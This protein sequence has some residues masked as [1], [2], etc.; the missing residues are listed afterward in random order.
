M[1]K[2]QRHHYI[3]GFYLKQWGDPGK[4]GHLIEFCRRYKGVEAR[5]TF[6]AGT[7]YVHGLYTFS[8]LDGEA[9]DFI[10]NVFL[11]RADTKAAIALQHLLAH[12]VDLD[13]DLKSAWSR[14]IMTLLHRSPEAIQRIRER[15]ATGLPSALKLLKAEWE[16]ARRRGDPQTFEEYAVSI[17]RRDLQQANLMVLHKI[18]DSENVGT[19]L[20]NMLWGVLTFHRPRYPLLTSDRPYVMTNGIDK[21]DGHIVLPISPSTVFIA[22]RNKETMVQIDATCKR[23]DLRMSEK[24]ND[25]VVR[26]AQKFVW[27]NDECQ[28]AF[29]ANRLGKQ[30]RSTPFG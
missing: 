17:P 16:T 6:P 30:Q 21:P 23:E 28:L 15:V 22:A 18:M 13:I 20:N 4:S 7:G 8:E 2:G 19:F 9:K 25:I 1:S 12:N 24:L 26:Q 14:F 29:V 5:P 10:E 27:G 3:P 11:L